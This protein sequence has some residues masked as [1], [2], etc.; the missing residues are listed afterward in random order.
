MAE[1]RYG[2]GGAFGGD[3]KLRNTS[4]FVDMGDGQKIAAQP[5]FPLQCAAAVRRAIWRQAFGAEG[6]KRFL[7]GIERLARAG[8]NP[9]L[10]ERR[11]LAVKRTFVSLAP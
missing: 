1:F 9:M 6:M 5:V 7:H 2:F 3:D 11:K 4:L 8:E 10:E